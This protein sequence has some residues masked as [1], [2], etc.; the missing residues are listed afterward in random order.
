MF[1]LRQ[2]YASAS[3]V[4]R[5]S[6]LLLLILLLFSAVAHAQLPT[7]CIPDCEN[8]PWSGTQTALIEVPG[9]PGC[10]A[11]ILYV[12]RVACP[13]ANYNDVQILS[14]APLSSSACDAFRAYVNG[15]LATGGTPLQN[16]TKTLHDY[17]ASALVSKVFT[18][19][20][21]AMSPAQKAAVTCPNTTTQWRAARG[22]C[23]YYRRDGACCWSLQ[24]CP[25][26]FCC[27]SAYKVCW[28][29]GT[30][31]P[32][33]TQV[34]YSNPITTECGPVPNDAV[35]EGLCIPICDDFH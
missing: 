6:S 26:S 35:L 24:R 15:L 8:S 33:V 13:P 17:M 10:Y 18:D 11:V 25:T 21:N 22:S 4:I 30:G 12:T 3:T 32:I 34:P 9:F 23:V 2:M 5:G 7:P 1:S 16:Y 29:A 20:Y 14:I 19:R 31:Q 28:D 27:L